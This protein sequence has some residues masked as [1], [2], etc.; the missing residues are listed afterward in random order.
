MC[1]K[2]YHKNENDY[3]EGRYSDGK[4]FSKGKKSTDTKSRNNVKSML[5]K[6]FQ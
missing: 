4:H 5:K 3:Q 6:E 2:K 1:N